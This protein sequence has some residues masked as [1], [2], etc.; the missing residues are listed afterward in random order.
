MRS[1][2]LRSPA[3]LNLFLQVVNKR[4]DG[5]HNLET[6]FERIDLF[7]DLKLTL[8]SSG[9]IRVF[10]DHPD[11]PTDS[12][13]LVFKAAQLLKDDFALAEGVDFVIKKRIPV[14]AGL[15]GGSSNGATAL[16]GLSR[17]W[18]LDL[19]R[20]EL[21]AYARALGSDVPFFVH[22][23]SWA[24]GTGRGD[25]IK[26]IRLNR[27]FWHILFV[28]SIKMYTK[29]VFEAVNLELTKTNDDVNIFTRSLKKSDISVIGGLLRND[30][31]IPIIKLVPD[32]R[33]FKDY[34]MALK[35]QGVSFS[36]SGP[37]MF[38]LTENR[39]RAEEMMGVLQKQFSQVFA[40]RTF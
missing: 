2:S 33:K 13:N 20:R 15:A 1:L 14:A 35:A 23:C 31:E 40:V 29:E 16:L 26:P 22:D 34:M 3:K 37:A 18:K 32:L 6:V 30:L 36:G 4:P 11:V 39:E 5:Y 8:N 19:T 12:R 7:D 17:L 24:V 21:L 10:C 9:D 28:P 27:K 38:G 25:R